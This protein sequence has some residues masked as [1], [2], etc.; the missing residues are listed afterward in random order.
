MQI[1]LRNGYY[2]RHAACLHEHRAQYDARHDYN[3]VIEDARFCE[4][5]W[6]S[7]K[8]S[9]LSHFD[10]TGPCFLF[11][12][13]L[14]SLI[15]LPRYAYSL[16]LVNASSTVIA[17]LLLPISVCNSKPW[18]FSAHPMLA[19]SCWLMAPGSIDV[20]RMEMG[21]NE[22]GNALISYPIEANRTT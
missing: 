13:T 8:C 6:G 17:F 18:P 15:T 4:R 12:S 9:N 22:S 21:R 7:R 10:R 20:R 16:I 1:A 3:E 14:F 11:R 19:F 2:V 5:V